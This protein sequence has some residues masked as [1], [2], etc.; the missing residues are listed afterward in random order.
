MVTNDGQIKAT[1]SGLHKTL[2]SGKWHFA[3]V[4]RYKAEVVS[5]EGVHI[6]WTG[7]TGLEKLSINTLLIGTFRFCVNGK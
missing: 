2:L 5:L 7:L 3:E 6:H 1:D 4:C